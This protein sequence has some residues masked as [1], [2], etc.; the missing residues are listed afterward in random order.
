MLTPRAVKVKIAAF[1]PSARAINPCTLQ[2]F[3]V[4]SMP[5]AISP[6]IAFLLPAVLLHFVPIEVRLGCPTSVS[7]SQEELCQIYSIK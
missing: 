7:K 4:A 5:A 1:L 2:F 6:R 3:G